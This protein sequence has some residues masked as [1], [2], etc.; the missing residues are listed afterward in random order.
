MTYLQ[1]TLVQTE[2]MT[3]GVLPSLFVVSVVRKVLGDEL[4]DLTQRHPLLR[5]AADRHHDQGV[6][7]ERRL[8]VLL[9]LF[10]LLILLLLP[11][12]SLLHLHLLLLL[13]LDL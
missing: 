7:G 9:L 4:V 13:T 6:V 5:G 11:L 3:Y 10:C 8:L 1:E 2:V 12:S